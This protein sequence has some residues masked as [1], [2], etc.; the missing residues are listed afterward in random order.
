MQRVGPR[1]V[2]DGENADIS[3]TVYIDVKRR[4]AEKLGKEF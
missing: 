1:I 4:I 2:W 3:A